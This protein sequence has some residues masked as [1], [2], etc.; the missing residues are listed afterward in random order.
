[1]SKSGATVGGAITPD[2]T[3]I[4][5]PYDKQKETGEDVPP[6]TTAFTNSF[7]ARRERTDRPVLPAESRRHPKN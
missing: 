5:L 3:Q 4:P 1:M 6:R 7:T 2:S